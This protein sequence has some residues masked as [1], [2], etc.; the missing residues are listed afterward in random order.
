MS[1]KEIDFEEAVSFIKKH[2]TKM[3][4]LGKEPVEYIRELLGVG[5]EEMVSAKP[6]ELVFAD[7]AEAAKFRNHV[8]VCYHGNTSRYVAEAI[9]ENAMVETLSLRG[10]VTRIVG[11][12]F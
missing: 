9:N 6:N 11:E 8:F 2:R 5:S 7:K 4:W 1:V 10:G 12:I 3:V